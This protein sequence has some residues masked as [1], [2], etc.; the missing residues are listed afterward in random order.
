MFVT[1]SLIFLTWSLISFA[2]APVFAW[3]DWAL[4]GLVGEGRGRESVLTGLIGEGCG[5]ESVLVARG[6]VA[7]SRL[8]R[9]RHEAVRSTRRLRRT[10]RQPRKNVTHQ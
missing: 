4:T 10:K 7:L 9:R 2:F 6:G 8:G 3:Y 1:S 5:R